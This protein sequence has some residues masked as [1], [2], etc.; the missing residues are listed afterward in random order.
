M[1]DILRS[2]FFESIVL[3]VCVEV[4]AVAVALARYRSWPT[5]GRR[6]TIWI[7]LIGCILLI[8]LQQVIKTDRERIQAAVR[9]M[10]TAIDDG[11]VLVLGEYIDRDFRDRNSNRQAWLQDVR[12][13]LQRWQ[14]DNAKVGGFRIEVNGDQAVASFW[15]KCNG[16]SGDQSEQGVFSSWRLAFVRRDSGWK[17]QRVIGGK[18]NLLDYSDIR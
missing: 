17:L 1:L 5:P 6:L 18:V 12:L 10:A 14:I 3:L 15:A 7:A 11:D 13:W 2:L 16:R 8:V 9:A 4:V